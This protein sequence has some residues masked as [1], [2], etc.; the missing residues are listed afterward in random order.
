MSDYRCMMDSLVNERSGFLLSGS[1]SVV[2]FGMPA[3]VLGDS[4]SFAS[5][6]GQVEKFGW[7]LSEKV[8]Y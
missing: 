4:G 8:N 3:V 5:T 2:R 6:R 7:T 1:K